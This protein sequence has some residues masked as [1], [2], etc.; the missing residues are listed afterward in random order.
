[1][2]ATT[3]VRNEPKGIKVSFPFS[4]RQVDDNTV[5]ITLSDDGQPA[6]M[7]ELHPA[8]TVGEDDYKRMLDAATNAAIRASIT[9]QS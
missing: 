9:V 3:V 5:V 6:V 1:M 8:L 4:I 2:K 7:L